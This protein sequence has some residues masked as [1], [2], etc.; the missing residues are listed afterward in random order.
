MERL[1]TPKN[2]THRYFSG[3]DQ[4]YYR[5]VALRELSVRI[6]NTL[7]LRADDPMAGVAAGFASRAVVLAEALLCELERAESGEALTEEMN[8]TQGTLFQAFR[9]ESMVKR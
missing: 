9:T 8:M 7:L 4:L 2:E 5:T 3:D 1:N 6:H